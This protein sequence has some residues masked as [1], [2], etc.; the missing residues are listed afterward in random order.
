MLGPPP[1]GDGSSLMQHRGYGSDMVKREPNAPGSVMSPRMPQF[2]ERR[3]SL[4]RQENNARPFL[5]VT[6]TAQLKLLCV[7]VAPEARKGVLLAL[8]HGA[9]LWLKGQVQ[10]APDISCD[11]DR[12]P[13][14]SRYLVHVFGSNDIEVYLP[15]SVRTLPCVR[16]GTEE[17][18]TV[19]RSDSHLSLS[20]RR[21]IFDESWR[22]SR[23]R[24]AA[25]PP[26][27]SPAPAGSP[28][29]KKGRVDALETPVAE[30]KPATDASPLSVM[31]PTSNPSTPSNHV[32]SPPMIMAQH[33]VPG[34]DHGD[35]PLLSLPFYAPGDQQLD[36]A[37]RIP[38]QDE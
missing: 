27:M 21:H 8:R 18:L 22:L 9:T 34:A 30:P 20:F 13:S 6:L 15:K 32:G 24:R 19:L 5:M 16:I 11:D 23:L 4:Q 35:S 31:L 3:P 36:E 28:A 2:P 10:P 29:R 38:L 7:E 26:A 25:L 33:V 12:L 1:R 17:G 14:L 37:F